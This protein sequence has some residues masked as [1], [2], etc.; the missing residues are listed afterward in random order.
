MARMIKSRIL[1]LI[2]RGYLSRTDD[3]RVLEYVPWYWMHLLIA[4]N[5][6]ISIFVN[7]IFF[8]KLKKLLKI[9][10]FK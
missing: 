3:R 8:S 1:E 2:E 9:N 6:K 4:N 5:F 7:F 10:K